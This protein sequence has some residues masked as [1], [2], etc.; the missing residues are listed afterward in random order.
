[1]A[2]VGRALIPAVPDDSHTSLG[3]STVGSL[4]V[5]EMT[6]RTWRLGLRPAD[7]TLVVVDGA[8]AAQRELPLA[9]RT[10]D[11]AL[12]WAAEALGGAAPGPP[13]YPMPEHAVGQGGEFRGGDRD[14]LAELERWYASA[15][16]LLREFVSSHPHAED[17]VS[18][19]R[20]WPHH[21]DIATLVSIPGGAPG[22]VRTIGVGLSPGDGSYAEPYFYVTPWPAPDGPTLPELPAGAAWHRAGWFGAVLTGTAIFH[23]AEATPPA[24][25]RMIRDFLDGAW[26]ASATLL[27][28]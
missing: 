3:W 1:V 5:G 2:S 10:F 14:A 4:L 19:V 22:E 21:F 27:G 13:P 18:P 7:L 6:P 11:Q 8:G 12:A 25:K 24:R 9:G 23:D 16:A 20:C 15:D 28:V 26:R 17:R